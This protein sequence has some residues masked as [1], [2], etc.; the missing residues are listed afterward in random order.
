[1]RKEN[2]QVKVV[3]HSM[4]ILRC[5]IHAKMIY[6]RNTTT[7]RTLRQKAHSTKEGKLMESEQEAWNC[8]NNSKKSEEKSCGDNLPAVRALQQ[9]GTHVSYATCWLADPGKKE[10]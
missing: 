1:M 5:L 7:V 2:F 10:I 4:Q 3:L 6:I 8:Q 9:E